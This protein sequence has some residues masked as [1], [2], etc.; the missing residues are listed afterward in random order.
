MRKIL[1][2]IVDCC[3]PGGCVWHGIAICRGLCYNHYHRLKRRVMRGK[4]TWEEAEASGECN[5]VIS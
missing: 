1:R 3:H 2:K 5:P 4:T